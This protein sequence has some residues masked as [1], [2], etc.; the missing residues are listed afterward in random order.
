LAIALQALETNDVN[1][2]ELSDSI[3]AALNAMDDLDGAVAS[4]I[5][6]LNNFDPGYDENDITSFIGKVYKNAS[7]NIEKGA[8]GN[9]VMGNYMQKIFGEFK[10]DGPKEGYGDAYKEWLNT[11]LTWLENNQ[12]S[13]YSAWSD[14][15]STLQGGM[16]DA[17]HIYE[18]GGEI[19]IEANN[20]TTD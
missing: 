8:Y 3:I 17:A 1:V 4:I 6:E 14:F 10:Y 20:M 16:L 5:D 15:A 9:N 19:F 13:M 18:Q 7:E 12:D 11:N 2:W